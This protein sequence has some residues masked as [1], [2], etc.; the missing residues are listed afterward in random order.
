MAQK[1]T[2]EALETALNDLDGWEVVDDKLHKVFKFDSFAA[3]LGW[4]VAVGVKAD[5]MDHHPEWCNVYNRVTVDL[6]THY[7]GNVVSELDVKL[8]RA[9]DALAPR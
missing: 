8:A 4:M 7:L 6:T 3:A 1:L 2:P 5:K 9:M